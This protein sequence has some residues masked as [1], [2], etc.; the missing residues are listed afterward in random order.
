MRRCAAVLIVAALAGGV[1]RAQP[2]A[3]AGQR[4]AVRACAGCHAIGLSGASRNPLAPPFR[5]LGARLP[6]RALS[7]RLRTISAHGHGT[8]PPIYMTPAERRAVAAYI[9]LLSAHKQGHSV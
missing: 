2:A 3:E 9:R 6:G 5:T 1:A 7:T 4:F 8:M